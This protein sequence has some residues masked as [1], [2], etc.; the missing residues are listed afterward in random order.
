MSLL[1][2]TIYFMNKPIGCGQYKETSLCV[3]ELLVVG[4]QHIIPAPPLLCKV[5][6]YP[7][8]NY[9]DGLSRLCLSVGNIKWV[10]FLF[11]YKRSK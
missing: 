9:D 11:G 6:Q 1:P 10:F 7:S 8:G 3:F 5:P 2:P 4:R